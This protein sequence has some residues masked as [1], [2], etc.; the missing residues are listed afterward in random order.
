MNDLILSMSEQSIFKQ[1]HQQE[2]INRHF[3]GGDG[4]G[5]KDD[6]EIQWTD[7]S[8]VITRDSR[9]YVQTVQYNEQVQ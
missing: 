7:D 2:V 9:D 5:Y 1:N 8:N 6:P 4:D 3:K